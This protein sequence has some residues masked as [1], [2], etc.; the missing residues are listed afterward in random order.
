METPGGPTETICRLCA[1]VAPAGKWKLRDA[2]LTERPLPPG[3]PSGGEDE[4]IDRVTGTCTILAGPWIARSPKYMPPLRPEGFAITVRV[5]GVVPLLGTTDNHC[6]P[7]LV[8]AITVKAAGCPLLVSASVFVP[9]N[10]APGG[11]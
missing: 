7:E 10:G 9:S 8:L 5:A 4:E 1:A 11:V 6:P 3:T 2:G